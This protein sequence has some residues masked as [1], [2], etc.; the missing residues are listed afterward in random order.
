MVGSLPAEGTS[1]VDR[2]EELAVAKQVL[3]TTRLLTL[4]GPG[5]VGKSRLALR[6]ANQ[7]K[8]AFADGVWMV[9]L[10]AIEDEAL[11]AV[12]VAH[13]LRI[14]DFADLPPEKVLV[15]RLRDRRL[16]VV[17]DNAEHVI[18]ACGRL[19]ATL[20]RHVPAMRFV[21]T[22]RHRLG[23]TEEHLL[24]V[25][26]LKTNRDEDS[27]L[28]LFVERAAAVAPGFRLTTE[29]RNA[30]AGLCR[31]LDGLPLAIE[32]AAV[33]MREQGIEQLAERLADGTGGLTRHEALRSTVEWS[34]GLCTPAEQ[35]VWARASVFAGGFELE[36]AEA[37]CE[38]PDVPVEDVLDAV[39]GLVDKSVLV[40]ERNS[41]RLRYRM[42]E[43]IRHYG[44]EKL[45][46]DEPVIRRRHRDWFLELALNCERTWFGPGQRDTVHLLRA[47]Q[48]NIRGA[49]DYCLTTEGEA[50]KGL[51]L[52]GCLWFYWHGCTARMEGRYWLDLTLEANPAPTRERARGLW[53]AGL[54]ANCV[55]DLTRGTGLALESKELALQLGDAAE[56]AHAEHVVGLMTLFRDNLAEARTLFEEAV[57]RPRVPGQLP[58]LAALDL[59]ELAAALAFDGN[60]DWA[61]VVCDKARLTC[62]AHHEEWV[63]SYVLRVRALAHTVKDEWETAEAY[64]REALA[65]KHALHDMVGTGLT[66][67]LLAV[68]AS[69]RQ[70]DERAA[71]LL[72]VADGVWRD[73][74][75]NRFGSKHYNA[76]QRLRAGD[77]AFELA[78]RRGRTRGLDAGVAY[79][80][81]QQTEEH[82]EHTDR[83]SALTR[84]ESEVASL[85]AEGLS[86]QEIADRLVIA[87]RTAEG[88]VERILGKLGFSSRSQIATW[89]A[90]QRF[91][92]RE[93]YT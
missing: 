83:E 24:E 36:A 21:V 34:Y 23:L 40:R 65:L 9:P 15:E 76:S 85:V 5:G 51:E 37:V 57:A 20:L 61:I 18:D 48:D 66:L 72:G 81:E 4:T 44:R 7:V 28:S 31:T 29:N 33:G 27:A 69:N 75:I 74:D 91:G 67:D 50:R 30:V 80:L 84:R 6:L 19:V 92:D 14:D 70:R 39:A 22:S 62:E 64:A 38:G 2:R 13:A 60:P 86:N 26:P 54:L 59:V 3:S 12:A 71:V 79:A 49:L 46:A 41:D 25:G 42:L 8:R 68:I 45:G 82:A 63:L 73:I 16:L 93:E 89:V 10:A 53:V 90:G 56:A 78:Y 32:L 58:S 43:T 1:F 52:A 77:R 55:E 17:L 35:L 11:V 87:R 47:E 88:H